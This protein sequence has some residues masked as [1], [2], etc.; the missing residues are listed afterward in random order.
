MHE[1]GVGVQG[2]VGAALAPVGFGL[3]AIALLGS[4]GANAVA[5]VT[6][7]A[8]PLPAA[9]STNATSSHGAFVSYIAVATDD[10][11]PASLSCAPAS[12]ARLPVGQT[13]ITCTAMDAAG[14]GT[15]GSFVITVLGASEQL[16][17]LRDK[18][19]AMNLPPDAR[20]ALIELIDAATKQIG[21]SHVQAACSQTTELGGLVSGLTG[22]A[23]ELGRPVLAILAALDCVP[24]T[25]RPVLL[26]PRADVTT[27]T[28]PG[29]PTAKVRFTGESSTVA[30]APTSPATL[31]VGLTKATC[32]ATNVN[33]TTK[34]SF[35][36]TVLDKEP[37]VLAMPADIT[38]N[39][40]S[41]SSTAVVTFAPTATDNVGI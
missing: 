4:A 30:C 29:L 18:V 2:K 26:G 16:A 20:Q 38:V 21:K 17:L 41:G 10:V 34:T 22:D 27:T 32:T 8:I 11:E 23:A 25:A 39:A 24:S 19:L 31:G 40:P 3:L 13:T 6:P 15:T 28:S 35:N 1:G 7:R 9:T 5:D 12:G 37:P 33:G 36:M 14:H